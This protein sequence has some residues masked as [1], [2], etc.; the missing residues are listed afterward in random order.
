MLFV[1]LN[2]NQHTSYS[3]SQKIGFLV[4]TFLE[5]V[6][7]AEAVRL[8]LVALAVAEVLLTAAPTLGLAAE[9]RDRQSRK[10]RK[11]FTLEIPTFC[12]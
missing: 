9:L 12:K 3:Y 2:S 10:A 6:A 5:A 11:N 8:V 4:Q 1:C 7:A